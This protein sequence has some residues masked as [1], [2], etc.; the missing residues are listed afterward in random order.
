MTKEE[1]NSCPHCFTLAT[2]LRASVILKM[3]CIISIL[4]SICVKICVIGTE[5][6]LQGVPQEV[7]PYSSPIPQ[8]LYPTLSVLLCGIGVFFLAWFFMYD[9]FSFTFVPN[10]NI[11]NIRCSYEVTSNTESGTN[12]RKRNLTTELTLAAT[13]SVFLGFGT[14]FLLLWTG[15]YI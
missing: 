4:D 11:S 9:F 7:I 13:A 10:L 15:V 3:V 2:L 1:L 5:C 12:K 14:I 8:G 6:E